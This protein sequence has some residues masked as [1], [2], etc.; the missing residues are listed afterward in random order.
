ME[1][2]G[3]L[4]LTF[5]G[6]LAIILVGVG[7]SSARTS[8]KLREQTDLQPMS[9]ADF[10]GRD[11]KREARILAALK[12]HPEAA[13]YRLAPGADDAPVHEIGLSEFVSR[14]IKR[15]VAVD[16]ET[17]GLYEFMDDIIE[18]AAVRV[19]DGAITGE[20]HTLVNPMRKIPVKASEIN[21]I[22]DY[23][24]ADSPTLEEALPELLVFL[25]DDPIVAH[26]SAFEMKFIN[27]ACERCRFRH[28]VQY[29]DSRMLATYFPGV[30]DRKL[31]T[32]LDAAG[33]VNSAPH[34]ALGDARAL[35]E[36]VILTQEERIK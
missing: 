16:L 19:E 14:Q 26:Y 31:V 11:R 22:Y 21:H 2:I 9:A 30:P 24:V 33:I 10:E 28:P 25:G 29:F 35:A 6:V 7:V 32:L 18:I 13:Q 4:I 5:I 20:F 3:I 12:K 15:F 23:M 8:K 27:A 17:T 34:R 1:F 36:F